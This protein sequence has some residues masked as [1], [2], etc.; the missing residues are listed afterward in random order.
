MDEKFLVFNRT[1]GVYASPDPMTR[2][3]AE[4]FIT[5]F[6]ARFEPQGYYASAEGRIPVADV[7][8]VL[9]PWSDEEEE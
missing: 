1:D 7:R 6:L 5:A 9:E 4:R 3:E 8:L 2:A